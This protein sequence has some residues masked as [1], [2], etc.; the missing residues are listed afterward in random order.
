MVREEK[1]NEEYDTPLVGDTDSK[2]DFNAM[3][4]ENSVKNGKKS[5][6]ES[7]N[8][9]NYKI[10]EN[11]DGERISI[12]V[13]DVTDKIERRGRKK[14]V[15]SKKALEKENDDKKIKDADEAVKAGTAIALMQISNV[16]SMFTSE[17]W[18]ITEKDEALVLSESLNEYLDI[19]FPNWKSAVPEMALVA[20]FSVYFL[21][22]M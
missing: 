14:G 5:G 19:R 13:T 9:D 1:R 17:K 15:K 3:L 8:L 7:G 11:P 18:K 20:S 21:K 16:I 4:F 2:D 10:T 22:R 12:D 6:K